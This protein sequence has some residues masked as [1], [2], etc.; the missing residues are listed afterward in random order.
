MVTSCDRWPD[1]ATKKSRHLKMGCPIPLVFL[2]MIPSKKNK[3]TCSM[4]S[5]TRSK[6]HSKIML[7]FFIPTN[8]QDQWPILC[9]IKNT[10]THICPVETHD[11]TFWFN[12]SHSA[13]AFQVLL[14]TSPDHHGIFTNCCW[15]T[16]QAPSFLVKSLGEHYFIAGKWML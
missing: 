4:R 3:Q 12:P 7:F 2:I 14:P 5:S 16:P 11:N 13:I 1:L 10:M 6:T 9:P 8:S 15:L